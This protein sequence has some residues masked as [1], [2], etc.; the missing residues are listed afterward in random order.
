[1]VDPIE[2][3]RLQATV[4]A[5]AG[6]LKALRQDLQA[7]RADLNKLI[8]VAERGKGAL[9]MTLTVGGVIGGFLNWL[10]HKAA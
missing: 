4:E 2:F 7:V 5:Q 8:V 6:E 10:F 1:M 9:W 3:G